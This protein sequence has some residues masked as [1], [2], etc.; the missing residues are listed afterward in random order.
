MKLSAEQ[1]VAVELCPRRMAWSNRYSALRVSPVRAL[2]MALDAGLRTEK[3]PEKAAENE[4]LSL[5]ANPGLDVTGGDTYAIAMHH[6]KVAGLLS[7]ALRSTTTQ[8]WKPVTEVP[9][10][11]DTW[12]SACYDMGDGKAR[13]IALVDRWSDDRKQQEIYGWRTIGEACA[14]DQP[15]YLTAV[16]IGSAHDKRRHS[17]WTR[18]YRHPRNRTYRM[19]R[20]T[21][22]EDFSQTWKREWRED[23]GIST[24][25]W[26]AQ[27]K[28][29]GCMTDLVHTVQVPV[30]ARRGDYLADMVRLAGEMSAA[31]DAPRFSGCFGWNTCP[32]TVV[33]HGSKTP[34]VP[35]TYGF[36]IK[37]AL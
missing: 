7:V 33:C 17:P 23:A 36:R 27:M 11:E 30:P 5:A 22:E 6:A 29:D 28:R 18:C 2:Y 3:D 25:D 14:L 21:S 34:A 16:T 32:F 37:P 9:L 26:L 13:R 19:M 8:P 12:Q 10:G 1:L 15:I 24:D 31:N 35:E 4:L 20:K